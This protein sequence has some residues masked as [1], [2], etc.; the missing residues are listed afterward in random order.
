L[1]INGTSNAPWDLLIDQRVFGH[2]QDLLFILLGDVRHSESGSV[3]TI[4][5]GL[6]HDP[7]HTDVAGLDS[8]LDLLVRVAVLSTSVQNAQHT[9]NFHSVAWGNLICDISVA[10]KEEG[11]RHLT[12]GDK[13]G[14]LL[15]LESL[16]IN[17]LTKVSHNLIGVELALLLI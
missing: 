14:C 8:V 3:N 13:F 1:S 9:D 7:Y 11:T 6:R 10:G 2:V 15:Q 16:L 4:L 17:I 5:V 12:S